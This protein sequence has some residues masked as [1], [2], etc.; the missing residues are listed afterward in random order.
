MQRRTLLQSTLLAGATALTSPI[1]PGEAGEKADLERVARTLAAAK[2]L[3]TGGGYDRSWSSSGSPVE[4]RQEGERILSASKKGTYCCGFTFAAAMG[5]LSARGALA[6]KTADEVR[7]FQKTWFGATPKKDEQERQCAVA[8]A[9]LGVGVS[10]S[11]DDAM[12]GDFV[13]LWR[14]SK[15][16]S[17]HSVLFLG[18][19]E[20][21]D[22]R[23]G[24]SY[25]SSQGSTKG[26]GFAV[27]Y[28][29][30]SGIEGGRVDEKRLYFARLTSA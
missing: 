19:V 2:A 10:V 3:G 23:I 1:R 18:W 13:Q 24:L 9:Q 29:A 6:G 28:F 17:G 22:K 8:V 12:A 15:K 5:A 7:A 25:L 26:I 21:A 27:E 11:A 14:R 4:I 20:V 30:D 16:P